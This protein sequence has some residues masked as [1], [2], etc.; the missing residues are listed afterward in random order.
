MYVSM[1]II[2]G[3]TVVG[4]GINGT[5]MGAA[6]IFTEG[7][8]GQA[9]RLHGS[10]VRTTSTLVTILTPALETLNTALA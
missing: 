7:K 4:E 8:V 2:E 5:L 9:V 1:D 10:S 6:S 3:N